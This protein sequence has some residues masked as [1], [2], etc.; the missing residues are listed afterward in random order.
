MIEESIRIG[1]TTIGQLL[2][3]NNCSLQIESNYP[4]ASKYIKKNDELELYAIKKPKIK[5]DPQCSVSDFIHLGILY[6]QF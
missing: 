6:L 2:K 3:E 1:P 5:F 4:F